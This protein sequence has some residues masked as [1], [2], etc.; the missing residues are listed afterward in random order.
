MLTTWTKRADQTVWT[1]IKL[2]FAILSVLLDTSKD[3]QTD[4]R[5]NHVNYVLSANTFGNVTIVLFFIKKNPYLPLLFLF[6]LYTHI[7]LIGLY[8]GKSFHQ[9]LSLFQYHRHQPFRCF[10]QDHA[11]RCV[12]YPLR[13]HAYSNILKI[14]P[15]RKRT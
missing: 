12:S 15:T 11:K 6:T 4:L 10:L 5:K 14:S 8:Y 2:P 7:F 9:V 13:K 3:S 1:Q